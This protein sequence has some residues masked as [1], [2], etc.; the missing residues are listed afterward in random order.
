MCGGVIRNNSGQIVAHLV[1]GINPLNSINPVNG[2]FGAVNT[3][4]LHKIGKD[5]KELKESVSALQAATSQIMGLATGTMILSGL[6]L[7]VSSAGFTFLNKKLNKI[8]EKL[9]QISEDVKTIKTFLQSQ[10]RA[11]LVTALKTLSGIEASLDD[12]T[13]IQL[14]VNARQTLGVIHERYR[15]QLLHIDRIQDID[16]IEEYFTVTALGHAMCSAELDMHNNAVTDLVDAY[17]TWQLAAR[18]IAKDLILRNDPERLLFSDYA[19]LAKTEEIIDWMDFTY[20]TEKEITWIDDLRGKTHQL[21]IPSVRK[22]KT[23]D[24][25]IENMRRLVAR[26]RIYDGYVSQYRYLQSV[27]ARPSSLQN[28]YDN[29]G[30]EMKIGDGYLFISDSE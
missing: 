6:T 21:R 24:S 2:V 26:N 16:A 20:G 13:R 1:N 7:A 19:S 30:D 15:D 18:R 11:S 25:E 9:T 8:D 14:L 27:S 28:Y 23:S 10:E 5:I 4:Q 17:E 3:F 22:S 29:L 12:Q